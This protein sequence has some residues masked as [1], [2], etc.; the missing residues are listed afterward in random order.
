LQMRCKGSVFFPIGQTITKEKVPKHDFRHFLL[1]YVSST[2]LL[3]PFII[4]ISAY[5]NWK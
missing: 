2:F 1:I 3:L 5:A 4:I